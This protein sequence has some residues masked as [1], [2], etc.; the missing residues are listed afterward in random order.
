[1]VRKI[2]NFAAFQAG[3]FAGV[4]GAAR[5]HE[6]LGIA[7]IA[8]VIAVH[9]FVA[10]DRE[11]ESLFL[12]STLPVGLVVDQILHGTGAVVGVGD[13]LPASIAPLWLLAMWPLFGTLFNEV[14]SWMR[15]RYLAAIAFGVVGAPLSY[16][17]GV[18]FGAVRV[19]ENA[20][21]WLVLVALTWGTAMPAILALQA[22]LTPR[23]RPPPTPRIGPRIE[24]PI[25]PPVTP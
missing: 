6:L 8:L 11:G 5:G 25:E 18:K 14:M 16:L 12:L 23:P 2:Y 13:L 15:G 4:L 3:W 7:G 1:M 24:P 9:L 10:R 20:W 22:R 19:H 21:F 17:A